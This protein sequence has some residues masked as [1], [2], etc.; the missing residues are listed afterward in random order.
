MEQR[1]NY[2]IDVIRFIMALLIVAL[3]SNPFA[4]YNALISYFPSQVL[5]RL[6]VP[7]FAA[8]AGYFFFRSGADNKC[9]RTILRYLQPYVLWSVIYFIYRLALGEIGGGYITE[10]SR[11]SDDAF[12]HGV[13]SPVVYVG[14]Y[15]YGGFAVDC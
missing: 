8:V 11:Y 14:Y 3:H 2:T 4:E 5:S 10:S 13:L 15:L 12:S 9:Q 7:F 6:G 1:R